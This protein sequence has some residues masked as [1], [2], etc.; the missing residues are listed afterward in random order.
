MNVQV[1]SQLKLCIVKHTKKSTLLQLCKTEITQWR[2]GVGDNLKR[3]SFSSSLFH[4]TSPHYVCIVYV[5]KYKHTHTLKHI[6]TRWSRQSSILEI[7]NIHGSIPCFSRHLTSYWDSLSL[8]E[9]KDWN[10]FLKRMMS[11]QIN[12]HK[13]TRSLTTSEKWP[14][15]ARCCKRPKHAT[16]WSLLSAPKLLH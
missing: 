11:V 15:I 8:S 5:L 16:T 3:E 4:T 12:A 9:S 7:F 2:L 14:M 13:H 6:P 1:D 10:S